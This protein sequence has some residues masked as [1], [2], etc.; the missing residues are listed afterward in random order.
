MAESDYVAQH[1]FTIDNQ[2]LQILMVFVAIAIPFSL[3][4]K[5]KMVFLCCYFN[6][7]KNSV[8]NLWNTKKTITIGLEVGVTVADSRVL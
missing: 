8:L 2:F 4:M 1:F 5:L 6:K 3:S 7:R